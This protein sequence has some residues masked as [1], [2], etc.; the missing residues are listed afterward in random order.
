MCSLPTNCTQPKS[1]KGAT[2]R[3]KIIIRGM[4]AQACDWRLFRPS[5]CLI[6]MVNGS[7]F[8]SSDS[9]AGRVCGFPVSKPNSPT[10]RLSGRDTFFLIR[11]IVRCI[12]PDDLSRL[13]QK[14]EF[15]LR[16]EQKEKKKKKKKRVWLTN[17]SGIMQCTIVVPHLARD[18]HQAGN[19]ATTQGR[20]LSRPWDQR[21]HCAFAF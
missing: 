13:L 1:Q 11:P 2:A 6:L 4:V 15:P 20:I 21:W 3:G 12:I 7:N 10:R 18:G 9:P 16:R 8:R 5:E 17:K 19:C 14:Q